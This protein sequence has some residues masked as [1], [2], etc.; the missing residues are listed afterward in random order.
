MGAHA[1]NSGMLSFWRWRQDGQDFKVTLC[2]IPSSRLRI[3][4]TLW[5]KR[6]EGEREQWR[7]GGKEGHA[8][9]LSSSAEGREKQLVVFGAHWPVSLSINVLQVQGEILSPPKKKKSGENNHT[10]GQTPNFNLY[11][12]VHTQA[13]IPAH[14][15]AHVHTN[16]YIYH[17]LDTTHIHKTF[18]KKRR[19]FAKRLSS[20]CGF[21]PQPL[22][23]SP[24]RFCFASLFLSSSEIRGAL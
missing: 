12:C 7:E 1:C 8:Y 19:C 15:S 18:R 6:K 16:K 22:A 17:M 20:L 23:L 13:L 3:H 24:F 21:F 11:T 10:L 4:E 5:K 14:I 9:N 2:Y